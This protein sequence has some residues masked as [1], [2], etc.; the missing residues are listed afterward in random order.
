MTT[1]SS[2]LALLSCNSI[3]SSALKSVQDDMAKKNC[4]TAFLKYIRVD[5]RAINS[6]GRR[7]RAFLASRVILGHGSTD[8]RTDRSLEEHPISV[9]DFSTIPRPFF[10]GLPQKGLPRAQPDKNAF[11]H[12][13]KGITEKEV[14]TS[15]WIRRFHRLNHPVWLSFF[16]RRRM[17]NLEGAQEFWHPNQTQMSLTR[18][19]SPI[20]T[21]SK[22][23]FLT[24][25][26][27]PPSL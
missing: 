14:S 8:E 5:L 23:H 4:T 12:W 16:P 24:Y 21:L 10:L 20:I 27:S 1:S 19:V 18:L 7:K 2:T 15:I 25:S 13:V 22:M 17:R 3:A 6:D 11:I 26:L 9:L